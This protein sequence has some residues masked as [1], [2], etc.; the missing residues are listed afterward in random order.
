[1]KDLT[2]FR[3]EKKFLTNLK[4]KERLDDQEDFFFTRTDWESPLL[5]SNID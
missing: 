3:E 1:M 4:K 2:T 5:D